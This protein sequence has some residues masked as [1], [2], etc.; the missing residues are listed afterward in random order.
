[1]LQFQVFSFTISLM[2]SGN[3]LFILVHLILLKDC[4]YFLDTDFLNHKKTFLD[5]HEILYELGL[6]ILSS[7]K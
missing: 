1:M 6:I 4:A 3:I 5:V 7:V 2:Y